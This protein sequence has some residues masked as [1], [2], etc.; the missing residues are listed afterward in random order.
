LQIFELDISE[1]SK[2]SKL[3][4]EDVAEYLDPL[5]TILS[6]KQIGGTAPSQVKKEIKRAKKVLSQRK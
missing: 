4:K 6:R 5:K 3:I 1:L 2:F